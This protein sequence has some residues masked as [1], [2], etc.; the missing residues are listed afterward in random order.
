MDAYFCLTCKTRA[1]C[2]EICPE[3]ENYLKSKAVTN[4]WKQLKRKQRG[5]EILWDAL[6][7]EKLA[8]KQAFKLKYNWN[9]RQQEND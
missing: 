3:L 2:H 9:I 5:K 1:T 8:T 4:E 7:I 6:K